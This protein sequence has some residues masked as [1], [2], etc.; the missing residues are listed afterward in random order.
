MP[1]VSYGASRRGRDTVYGSRA[2]AAP[3]GVASGVRDCMATAYN[4]ARRGTIVALHAQ[5]L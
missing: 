1:P 3:A 2:R 4:A 5:P